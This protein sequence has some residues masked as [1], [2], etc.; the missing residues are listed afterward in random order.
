MIVMEENKNTV[1][2]QE[3]QSGGDKTGLSDSKI[4]G[5]LYNSK[6]PEFKNEDSTDDISNIDQQEGTMNR[7]ETGGNLNPANDG[8]HT[9]ENTNS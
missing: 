6:N 9:G 8:T 1:N 2:Q 4:E 3:S 7:G 5:R